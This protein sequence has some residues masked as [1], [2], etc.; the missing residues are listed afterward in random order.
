M[1][2][3][4]AVSN[5]EQPNNVRS[6]SQTS[7]VLAPLR[8]SQVG[9]PPPEDAQTRSE[10]MRHPHA[11]QPKASSQALV[12][13]SQPTERPRVT[14]PK[15]SS[16]PPVDIVLLHRQAV[17][18]AWSQPMTSGQ[19]AATNSPTHMPA[20]HQRHSETPSSARGTSTDTL[21]SAT[22]QICSPT[23]FPGTPKLAPLAAYGCPPARFA[24]GWTLSP[25]YHVS[26]TT[27]CLVDAWT[28]F[29]GTYWPT[30]NAFS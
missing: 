17:S 6:T 8:P 23:Y 4:P 13:G 25:Q 28:W 2:P 21:S 5:S 15:A 27:G 20:A 26:A 16:K 9:N 19:Q 30:A 12:N 29:C 3:G 7:Q 14:R 1:S 18:E 11:A 24:A 22:C 10:V